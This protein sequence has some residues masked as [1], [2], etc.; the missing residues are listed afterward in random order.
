MKKLMINGIP[1][2]WKPLQ[3]TNPDKTL[4][5]LIIVAFPEHDPDAEPIFLIDNNGENPFGGYSFATWVPT[6]DVVFNDPK[7][8]QE[9]TW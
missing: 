2:L 9:V 5:K 3:F 7:E 1:Y 8:G 4:G 6:K